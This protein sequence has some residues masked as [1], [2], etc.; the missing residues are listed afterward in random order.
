[1]IFVSASRPWCSSLTLMSPPLADPPIFVAEKI[2]TPYGDI[3][4]ILNS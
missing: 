1:M 4:K 3:G 2:L